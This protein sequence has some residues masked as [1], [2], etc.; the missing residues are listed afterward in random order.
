MVTPATQA[1]SIFAT[2]IMVF[3]LV[4]IFAGRWQDRVGPRRVAMTG[5]LVVG[6]RLCAGGIGRS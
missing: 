3:S 2:G 1:Q 4:M 5:G 6:G